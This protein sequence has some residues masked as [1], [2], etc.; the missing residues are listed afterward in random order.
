MNSVVHTI[1]GVMPPGFSFPYKGVEAWLPLGSMPVPPRGAHNLGAIARLKPGVTVEQAR[2]EMTSIVARLEQAYPD[3]NKGWKGHVEPM[4]NVVVGDAS[5]PLWILFGAVCVVLLI[6]CANV[7]NILLARA[8]A[9]QQ[10]MSVKAA[11]GASRGRIS[12][13]SLAESLMLSVRRRRLALLLARTGLTA[14]VALAGNAIPRSAEI[15]LDGSVF[16]FAAMLAVVT[17]I[18]FGLAPAWMNSG[19]RCANRCR[20]G[21]RGSSGERGRTRQAL[22]VA[23]VALTLLLLTAPACCSAVSSGFMRWTRGSAVNAS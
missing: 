13:S 10:E 7:A 14:F 18:V 9:R 8:S 17:G 20:A 3:A 6:A 5:R 1:L 15:R 11:L 2:A 22:I 16:A 23:E 21:G 19:R 12:G 4:M